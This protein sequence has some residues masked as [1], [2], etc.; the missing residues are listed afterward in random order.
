MKDIDIRRAA[1][2]M[3]K[4]YGPD[5]AIQ[6]AVVPTISLTKAA[7]KALSL[8]GRSSPQSMKWIV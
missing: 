8:G 6:S 2:Q 7:L 1:E 4:L 3:R 5:A